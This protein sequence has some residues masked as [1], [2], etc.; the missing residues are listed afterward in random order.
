VKHRYSGRSQ[1]NIRV[2]QG[3]EIG[4]ASLLL[5]KAEEKEEKTDVYIGGKVAMITKGAFL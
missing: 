5:L 3:Y 2:E 1:I 4:R